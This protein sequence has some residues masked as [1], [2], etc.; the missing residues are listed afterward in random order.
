MFG[1]EALEEALQ[2]LG[3]VLESRGVSCG[4]A[5]AGGSSLLLLGLVDRPT[6]DVDVVGLSSGE[7]YISAEPLPPALVQAVVDVGNALGLASN[8][9]NSGP[10]SLLDLGL[11]DGFEDRIT[12]R[13]YG[14]LDVH[15][16]DRSD[17]ICF[18]L[19]AAVDQGPR[20]KHF[21]D[22]QM[23]EPTEHELLRAARWT[24]THDPSP[25]FKELLIDALGALGL[26]VSHA[27]L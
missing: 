26:E 4:I 9:L 25:T 20:S 2:T 3:E 22:L 24:R 23:L 16:P 5:V 14:S 1:L 15:L 13:R 11:P 8:W 17:L 7:R 21:A 19:Y 10:T 27:D 12:V 6:A 18:K